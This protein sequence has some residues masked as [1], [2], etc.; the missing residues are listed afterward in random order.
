MQDILLESIEFLCDYLDLEDVLPDLK[1]RR[2]ITD[3]DVE[4]VRG[5]ES[6]LRVEKLLDIL[7][8]MPLSSYKIIMED[9]EAKRPD[10]HQKVKE[11]QEEHNFNPGSVDKSSGGKASKSAPVD[12]VPDTSTDSSQ[13]TTGMQYLAVNKKGAS[14]P[15]DSSDVDLPYDIGG[16][17]E[18]EMVIDVDKLGHPKGVIVLN[19]SNGDIAVTGAGCV[20]VYN[21]Q[22]KYRFNLDDTQ[23]LKNPSCVVYL[24]CKYYVTDRSAYVKYY[25]NADDG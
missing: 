12:K 22:G 4:V 19:A 15:C 14:K 6:N 7:R 20:F 17:W 11:L 25:I 5:K 16:E 9:L 8:R 13:V 21:V 2:A 10:L 3:A 23:K 24:S 18:K 1:A